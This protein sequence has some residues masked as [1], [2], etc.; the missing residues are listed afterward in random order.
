M[1]RVLFLTKEFP[2]N[3]YGGAGVHVEYLSRE[4]A[5]LTS[6]EVRSFG[7]QNEAEVDGQPSVQG[8]QIDESRLAAIDPRLRKV[9]EPLAV[10]LEWMTRTLT[11]MKSASS[12][13]ALY[14]KVSPYLPSCF[15]HLLGTTE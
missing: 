12:A 10:N 4:L 14:R 13:R 9:F 11:K 3:V 8:S 2:P 15:D 6:V 1:N 5:K 7:E